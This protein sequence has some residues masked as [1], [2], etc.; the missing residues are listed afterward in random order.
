MRLLDLPRTTS[1]RIAFR[2]LPLFCVASLALFGFLYW[3]TQSYMLARIDEWLT[4]EHNIFVPL[5][6]DLL[7]QRLTAHLVADPSLER[8]LTLFDPDGHRVA[9]SPLNLPAG[10]L[11]TMPQ[12]QIFQFK[13]L[14]G[15]HAIIFRAITHRRSSGDV[16]IIARDMD[17]TNAF[18]GVLVSIFVWGGCVTLIL[19]LFQAAIIGA[20]SVRRIDQV[21]QSIQRIVN[22]DLSER[23]PT[24]GPR[25]DLGR[26]VDV[27]NG[28]LGEL[29]RLMQE[30]KGVCDNIAHD[31]RTPL[32]RMLAGLERARR[33]SASGEEYAAAVDEAIAAIK[34]VLKTFAALMRIAE[35]ESGARKAGFTDTDLTE[36]ISDAVE[37]YEPAA[38]AKNVR[39]LHSC[40]DRAAF[41][42]GDP[43]LLF[44]A[45]ANLIDN[46]LKFTP[47]G[48]LVRVRTFASHDVVGIEVSDTGPG[49]PAEQSA[50]VLRRFYRAEESRHL[51]GSGLGLALV[52]AVAKLHAAELVIAD[53]N[54]GCRVSFL[55]CKPAVALAAGRSDQFQPDAVETRTPDFV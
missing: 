28:M 14:Q 38:E 24:R 23:L 17:A 10:L 52:A 36:I 15:R 6:R 25:D 1:F 11:A 42:H 21:T 27:I 46:A 22:G 35:V 50:S 9:G 45:A 7:R 55:M 44:E 20:D 5:D 54:P 43:S 18:S 41:V 47:P 31:L 48:G 19:A 29:E 53:G 37:L 34:D 51:P 32:T 13:I 26:L 33:R 30:V 4:R 3:Q 8:A 12:D 39:L 40:N 2:F 49:I 16:L